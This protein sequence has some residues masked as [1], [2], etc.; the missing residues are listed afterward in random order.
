M[1]ATVSGALLRPSTRRSAQYPRVESGR[2]GPCPCRMTSSMASLVPSLPSG[3]ALGL[4]LHCLPVPASSPPSQAP[5]QT[6]FL[7]EAGE[8]CL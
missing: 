5:L 4:A 7:Q 6:P 2:A 1:C 8:Q 3:L